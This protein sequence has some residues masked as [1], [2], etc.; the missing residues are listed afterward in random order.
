MTLKHK[1]KVEQSKGQKVR[2]LQRQKEENK[3]ANSRARE[4]ADKVKKATTLSIFV[5]KQDRE[6][7]FDMEE[8]YDKLE[9]KLR[10][11]VV[12]SLCTCSPPSNCSCRSTRE[13]EMEHEFAMELVQRL[14]QRIIDYLK[15]IRSYQTIYSK[16]GNGKKFQLMTELYDF[17]KLDEDIRRTRK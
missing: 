2:D 3:E 15:Q 6:R 1:E 7:E 9:E 16:S 10:E 8:V 4:D 12:L 5:D 13:K 17:S 14:D 11:V